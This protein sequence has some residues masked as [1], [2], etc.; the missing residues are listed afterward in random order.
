MGRQIQSNKNWL[1]LLSKI[2]C[3]PASNLCSALPWQRFLAS[4]SLNERKFYLREFGSGCG[5]PV[6]AD[7]E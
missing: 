6:P 2:S 1:N 4:K 5:P 3:K 7:S